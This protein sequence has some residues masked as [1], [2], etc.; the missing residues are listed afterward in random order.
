MRTV[1]ADHNAGNHALVP[2]LYWLPPTILVGRLDLML[3]DVPTQAVPSHDEF[4]VHMMLAA[5]HVRVRR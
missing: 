4:A 1:G 5:W 2:G 3:I